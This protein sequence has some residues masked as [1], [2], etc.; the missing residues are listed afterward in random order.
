MFVPGAVGRPPRLL[1][2]PL[3]AR[4][5]F[6]QGA[7]VGRF[8]PDAFVLDAAIS[9]SRHPSAHDVRA[10]LLIDFNLL[11]LLASRRTGRRRRGAGDRRRH[12]FAHELVARGTHVVAVEIDPQLFQP[13]AKNSATAMSRCCR[14]TRSRTKPAQSGRAG[15]GRRTATRKRPVSSWSPICLTTW[16]RR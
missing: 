10:E 12:R 6:Q 7:F 4:Q 8:G 15:S 13:R 3:A 5:V 1:F 14:P 9:G 16:R 2:A 11:K